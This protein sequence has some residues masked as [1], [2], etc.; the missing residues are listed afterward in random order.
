MWEEYKDRTLDKV[1]PNMNQNLLSQTFVQ[2][3]SFSQDLF[4]LF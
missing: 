4:N 3:N 2:S 1:K